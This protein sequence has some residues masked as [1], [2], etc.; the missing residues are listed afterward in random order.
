M[1]QTVRILALVAAVSMLFAPS[2]LSQGRH[3]RGS[4]GWGYHA[5]YDGI[6]DPQTVETVTGEVVGVCE[7]PPMKGM[8]NGVHLTLKTGKETLSVHLGPSWYIMNQDTRIDVKDKIEVTGSR[9]MFDGAPA[10]I[11]IEV[12]KGDETLKLRDGDGYPRWSGWR[13]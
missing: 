6:Y 9:V 3:G 11:A 7:A 10:L 1:K 4:G 8:S 2:L 12:K 5:S 13:R